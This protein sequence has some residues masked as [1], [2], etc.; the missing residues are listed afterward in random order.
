MIGSRWFLGTS[1]HGLRRE[2]PFIL[3][4]NLSMAMHC[5]EGCYD[6]SSDIADT[7]W[8]MK[9]TEKPKLASGPEIASVARKLG[10]AVGD[11]TFADAL[12][13]RVKAEFLHKETTGAIYPDYDVLIAWKSY[14]M[15]PV[16]WMPLELAKLMSGGRNVVIE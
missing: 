9:L 16:T 6:P 15:E 12:D 7:I 1:S 8:V 11:P 3:C 5:L 2:F 10:I 13:L 4:R 14:V